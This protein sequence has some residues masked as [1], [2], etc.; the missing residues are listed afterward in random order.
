[1]T[2]VIV[3]SL[4][5]VKIEATRQGFSHMFPQHPVLIEPLA[6]PSGV[7]PQPIG[8]DET[9]QGAINRANSAAQQRPDAAYTAGIEGGVAW[10]DEALCVFAWV[11]VRNRAGRLGTAQT[12]LFYLPQEVARLI[13]DEGI[14]LGEADDRVFGQTNSKQ[15]NGSIGLLTDNALTR[16][17]YYV[18]AVMMALIPFK[19]PHFTWIHTA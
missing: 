5:P 2:Q 8:Q 9:R 18:Q 17:D 14:E 11:A 10:E 7:R 16:T 15:A 1:M 19:K 12:G 13:R 4:N 3:A 6:V